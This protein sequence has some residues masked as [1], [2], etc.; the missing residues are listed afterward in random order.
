MEEHVIAA[1]LNGTPVYFRMRMSEPQTTHGRILPV[2]TRNKDR[3]R[4]FPTVA[5]AEAV[6]E[7]WG[8]FGVDAK[9]FAVEEPDDEC[10]K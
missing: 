1:D 10:C 5:A 4:R 8:L 9:P 6:R 2:W 3:A 7:E